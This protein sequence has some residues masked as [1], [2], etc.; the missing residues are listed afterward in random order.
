MKQ[1][2]TFNLLE[3]FF[4][5]LE[6]KRYRDIKCS[7]NFFDVQPSILDRLPFLQINLKMFHND[8]DFLLYNFYNSYELYNIIYY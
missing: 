4:R 8:N 5:S 3:N 1:V 2:N 6:K 7:I